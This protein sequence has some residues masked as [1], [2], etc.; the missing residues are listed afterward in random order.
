MGISPELAPHVEQ[1]QGAV[2]QLEE[3]GHFFQAMRTAV[4]A[5]FYVQSLHFFIE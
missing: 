4:D 1:Q 2:D 5:T 3:E